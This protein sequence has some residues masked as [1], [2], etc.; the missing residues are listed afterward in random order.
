MLLARPVARRLWAVLES[1]RA[2][3]NSPSSRCGEHG[4]KPRRFERSQGCMQADANELLFSVCENTTGKPQGPRFRHSQ[5]SIYTLASGC[6]RY[7]GRSLYKTLLVGKGKPSCCT[8]SP[9]SPRPIYPAVACQGKRK[10]GNWLAYVDLLP[11]ED[12]MSYKRYYVHLRPFDLERSG[13]LVVFQN[14]H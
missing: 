11:P 5:P 12:T 10:G 14:P 13:L 6:P 3:P 7:L 2:R 8:V 9:T 1:K 4:M